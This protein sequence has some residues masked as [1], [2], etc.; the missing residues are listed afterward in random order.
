MKLRT[1]VCLCDNVSFKSYLS[2]ITQSVVCGDYT[3][4]SLPLSYGVPQGSVLGPILYTL[5][6]TPIGDIKKHNLKYHMYADD[7]QLY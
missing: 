3:S 6:T 7:T 4:S 2:N 1:R 5:Y